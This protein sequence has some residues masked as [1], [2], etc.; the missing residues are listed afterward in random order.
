MA[1]YPGTSNAFWFVLLIA[2]YEECSLAYFLA[3]SK[4]WSKQD[5]Q[6]NAYFRASNSLKKKKCFSFWKLLLSPELWVYLL[7]IIISHLK[8]KMNKGAKHLGRDCPQQS[9]WV[10]GCGFN[11][12]CWSWEHFLHLVWFMDRIHLW[13]GAL[14]IIVWSLC[15]ILVSHYSMSDYVGQYSLLLLRTLWTEVTKC[16]G[17]CPYNSI[18]A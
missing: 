9:P 15:L 13:R 7:L 16:Q 10:G 4:V 8:E 5:S 12:W 3:K 18:T 11:T 2:A 17:L 6:R 1:V 14:A